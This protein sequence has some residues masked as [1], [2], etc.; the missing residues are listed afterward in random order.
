MTDFELTHSD[1]A[2]SLWQRLCFHLEDRLVRARQRNDATLSE[3][4]TAAL[5]G[6]IACLKKL[7][8]LG[9]DRPMLT[10]DEEQ[11]PL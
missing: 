6:E 3:P 4:E 2:S 10:G 5:R 9:A 1:K 11:P 8:A 7:L